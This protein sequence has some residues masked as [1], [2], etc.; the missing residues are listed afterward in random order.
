MGDYVAFYHPYKLMI[1]TKGGYGLTLS[2]RR[3]NLKEN[4]ENDKFH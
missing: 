3:D 2:Q 4:M 1:F